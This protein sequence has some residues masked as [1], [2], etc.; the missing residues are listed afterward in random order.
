MEQLIETS[1]PLFSSPIVK[2]TNL[3]ES[4]AGTGKKRL[5]VTLP[6]C[7]IGHVNQNNRVYPKNV[8]EQNL[9]EDSKFMRRLKER[10]VIGEFEH[11]ESGVTDPRRGSHL[12]EKVWIEQLGEDNP[13]KVPSGEYCMGTYITADTPNGR[14]LREWLELKVPIGCSTRGKGDTEVREGSVEWVK[15]NYELDTIDVVY[16]PSV[17]EARPTPEN[18]KEVTEQ[19]QTNMG[20]EGNL[21]G[22]V[23]IQPP[24]EIPEPQIEEPAPVEPEGEQ[25]TTELVTAEEVEKFIKELEDSFEVEDVAKLVELMG[26]CIDMLDRMAA[27]E[28]TNHDGF[29]KPI[30]VLSHVLEK[31]VTEMVGGKKSSE[32]EESG[33]E[34]EEKTEKVLETPESG[35]NHTVLQ[36][37]D[38]NCRHTWSVEG[39]VTGVATCPKCGKAVSTEVQAMSEEKKTVEEKEKKEEATAIDIV[40]HVITEVMKQRGEDSRKAF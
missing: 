3:V 15:E 10:R 2:K 35:V 40:K 36:C 8:W 17:A 37:D 9:T 25:V 23:D 32:E 31:R 1:A 26:R 4:E 33:E 24:E 19:A 18:V 12:W 5:R 20:S 16:E 21:S 30:V 38:P 13:Y 27:F 7:R 29:R 39:S 6:W 11:P 34:A 14:I 28:D 22:E